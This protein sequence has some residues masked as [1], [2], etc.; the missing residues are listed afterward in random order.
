MLK[1]ALATLLLAVSLIAAI[2]PSSEGPIPDC[3]PI[4]CE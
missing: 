4:G 2:P 1:T 3:A